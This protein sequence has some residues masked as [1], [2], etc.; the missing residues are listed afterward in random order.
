M[1]PG[2]QE[3]KERSGISGLWCNG[4]CIGHAVMRIEPTR[5]RMEQ[6][7]DEDRNMSGMGI[8]AS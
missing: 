3:Q 8:K 7:I 5:L 6:A 4:A 1:H 2:L